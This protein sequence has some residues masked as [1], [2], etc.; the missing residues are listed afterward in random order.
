[1][2]STCEL[3]ECIYLKW[4]GLD[5]L[6]RATIETSANSV[7][8]SVPALGTLGQPNLLEEN[9]LQNLNTLIRLRKIMFEGLGESSN[10]QV[11]SSYDSAMMFIIPS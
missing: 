11:M 1:M 9:D 8:S 7:V 10:V 6:A 2:V 4:Q 5:A 3:P